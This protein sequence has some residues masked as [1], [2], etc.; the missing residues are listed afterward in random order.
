[1]NETQTENDFKPYEAP[2]RALKIQ[3]QL[4]KV[5]MPNPDFEAALK[6]AAKWRATALI[7]GRTADGLRS[8]DQFED[9]Q[10]NRPHNSTERAGAGR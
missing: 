6:A 2:A 5:R 3:L 1:M 7:T 8:R 10:T 4:L 9:G